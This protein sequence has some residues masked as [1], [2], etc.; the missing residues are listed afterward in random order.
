MNIT[1]I[2]GMPSEDFFMGLPLIEVQAFNMV[3]N[4]KLQEH[5][6]LRKKKIQGVLMHLENM[7]IVLSIKPLE[8]EQLILVYQTVVNMFDGM[9]LFPIIN[10]VSSCLIPSQGLDIGVDTMGYTVVRFQALTD[11]KASK[12]IA[13]EIFN[14]IFNNA[15][16]NQTAKDVES[17]LERMM[18]DKKPFTQA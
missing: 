11:L 3:L 6:S 17:T 12:Q 16:I 14:S 9:K 2:E 1:H 8:R 4:N 10:Q 13:D 15:P 18:K 7:V 5:E